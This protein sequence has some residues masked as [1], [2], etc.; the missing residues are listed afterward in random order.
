MRRLL[1]EGLQKLLE[2]LICAR[3]P[4]RVRGIVGLKARLGTPLAALHAAPA[5]SIRSAYS[6]SI[7]TMA[8]LASGSLSVSRFSHSMPSTLS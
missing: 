3:C 6:P 7:Q 4:R 1:W 5:L 8:A 2:K